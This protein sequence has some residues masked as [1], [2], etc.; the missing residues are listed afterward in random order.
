MSILRQ[1]LQKER[2]YCNS[3]TG[4]GYSANSSSSLADHC[5]TIAPDSSTPLHEIWDSPNNAGSKSLWNVGTLL[6]DHK[7]QHSRRQ[8]L[9]CG[10]HIYM[11]R[12]VNFKIK[13]QLTSETE[14]ESRWKIVFK[15]AVVELARLAVD[16]TALGGRTLSSDNNGLSLLHGTS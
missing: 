9:S 1:I 13:Q 3:S 5:P 10:C 16:G 12:P 15:D 4:L 11:P 2:H 8:S 14:T 7:P 6:W